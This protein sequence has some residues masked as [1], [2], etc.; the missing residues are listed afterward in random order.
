[1]GREGGWDGREGKE[2]GGEGREEEGGNGRG[3]G[4]RGKGKKR[5]GD[6]GGGVEGPGK[7]S[8]AGPALALGGPDYLSY[9][10]CQI[11]VY[12]ARFYRATRSIYLSI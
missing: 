11:N 9:K 10:I 6:S 4:G 12:T 7:W 3:W 1:M 2:K 5:G 8:A